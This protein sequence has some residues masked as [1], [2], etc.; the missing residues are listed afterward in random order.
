L[1]AQSFQP[2]D[3]RIMNIIVNSATLAI[4][5]AKWVEELVR[6]DRMSAIRAMA[7]NLTHDLKNSMQIIKGFTRILTKGKFYPDQKKKLFQI[8]DREINKFVEMT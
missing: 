6:S 3:E 7:R 4:Q 8:I 2:G 5:N 1:Q